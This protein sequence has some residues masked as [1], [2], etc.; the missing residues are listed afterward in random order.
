MHENHIY[1]YFYIY[2][3]I[4]FK[5]VCNIK[6]LYFD[7][8]INLEIKFINN[9]INYIKNILQKNNII[10]INDY[11]E[12]KKLIINHIL[13]ILLAN[14]DN[15]VIL[16]YVDFDNSN[17]MK[18]YCNQLGKLYNLFNEQNQNYKSIYINEIIIRLKN[19]LSFF[20]SD[21]FKITGIKIITNIEFNNYSDKDKIK[22]FISILV[23]LMTYFNNLVHHINF[24]NKLFNK[25]LKIDNI[26]IS[27]ILSYLD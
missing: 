14:T 2:K 18:V 12:I 6:D 11:N 27:K 22:Y 5:Q 24:F 8:K 1:E 20:G 3:L 10:D 9:H 13:P 21:L 16:K 17:F 4:K 15:N 7:N 19:L 25:F 26:Y 23:K